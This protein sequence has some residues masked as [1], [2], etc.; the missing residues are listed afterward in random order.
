M[1][2]AY[3]M[4]SMPAAQ[5]NKIDTGTHGIS[6]DTVINSASQESILNIHV[7]CKNLIKLDKTSQSDPMVVMFVPINGKYIEISRTEAIMNDANPTFVKFFQ[8]AYIFETQQPLRFCIYDVDSEKAPLEK[9]DYIGFVDT[10]VQNLVSTTSRDITFEIQHPTAKNKRGTLVLTVEQASNCGTVCN[11]TVACSG[12]KKMRTFS[13]DYPYF[14]ISKISN[15]K[16]IPVFRS[17]VVPKTY[18]CTF[19][20]FQVPLQ[21][22]ADN[23]DDAN[24][25]LTVMDYRKNHPDEVIG[26]IQLPLQTL[27]SSVG[28]TFEIE[29]K[30]KRK[31]GRIRIINFSIVKTPTFFDYIRSGLQLNLITAIDFTASNRAPTDPR[32][33]HFIT[34]GHLNQYESCIWSVGSVVCPY[35]S[36][37]AFPVYGFG[38]KINGVVSHCFPLTFDPSNPNVQGLEG[39]AAVY[40]NS[41]KSVVL[42]GPT[43]FA[44]IITAASQVAQE[45][46][47]SSRTYSI[48]MI[49]TD[50]VINDMPETIDAIVAASDSPLSIIIV[51]IGYANFASMDQLDADEHPLRSRSG[52]T[53]KRDIVQFIPYSKYEA[54]GGVGLAQELLAEIPKQVHQFCST[55]GY[56]PN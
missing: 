36:D 19:K 42:S 21:N 6:N 14:Q 11:F 2:I 46:F 31:T 49:L 15:G 7:A 39:I 3:G 4:S 10:D 48:L 27:K 23:E 17:E 38:G 32:S 51:G 28:T 50:G 26:S 44:P 45:S 29:G 34:E 54:Q 40:R 22:I 24:I 53:M 5:S 52:V 37:Q 55:H 47:E 20:N 8:A 12:L 30:N 35:D 43:L 16:N 56:I 1:S 25:L 13:K 41:L 18:Q 33:L 9:H